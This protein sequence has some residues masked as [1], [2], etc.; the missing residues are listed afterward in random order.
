MKMSFVLWQKLQYYS[1][2]IKL[3][4]FALAFVAEFEK[5]LPTTNAE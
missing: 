5:R 3:K 4:R 2:L 1:F